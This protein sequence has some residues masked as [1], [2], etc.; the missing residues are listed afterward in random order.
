MSYR[1]EQCIKMDVNQ[2]YFSRN[3]SVAKKMK[4]ILFFEFISV[5]AAVSPISFLDQVEQVNKDP[6]TETDQVR[7]N[8]NNLGLART[9]TE[10]I[11]E[12]PDQDNQNFE[13]LG[14]IWTGG[15]LQIK[16]LN[17]SEF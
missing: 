16:F 3:N 11:K 13:N 17:F 4:P 14:P 1:L 10:K 2:T 12:I 5:I 9:R 6:R 7:K 8:F 15:S